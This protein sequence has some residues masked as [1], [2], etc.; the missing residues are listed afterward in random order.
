MEVLANMPAYAAIVETRLSQ[1]ECLLYSA[2]EKIK[3]AKEQATSTTTQVIEEY[4]K[5]NNFIQYV[6]NT[7][8]EPT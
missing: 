1:T 3:V 4:K 8:A 6:T 2:N 7:R 5:I